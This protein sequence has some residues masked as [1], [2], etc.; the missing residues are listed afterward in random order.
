MSKPGCGRALRADI[1]RLIDAFADL[2]VCRRSTRTGG[3]IPALGFG[4]FQLGGSTCREAVQ[5]A[6]S[7]GYRHVDT[8]E[9]YDNERAV[10]AALDAMAQLRERGLVRSFPL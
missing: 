1:A 10:G 9:Y 2:R 4:T 7:V 8:A 5:T 3:E 6:L